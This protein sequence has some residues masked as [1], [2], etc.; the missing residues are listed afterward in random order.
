MKSDKINQILNNKILGSS[1]LVDLLNKYLL[2]I[3]NK[4]SDVIKAVKSASM[5]PGHFEAINSYINEL[6][7]VLK[8]NS[9]SELVKFLKRYSDKAE[10]KIATILNR[11]Y[12]DIKN[13]RSIITL[14]RSGTILKILDLWN[15]KYKPPKVVI[16]EARPKYE[17]RSMA[18]ELAG[19]GIKVEL[20][21]DAMMGLY[22]PKV[23]AAVTGA[24]IILRS[25]NV[26]NKVGSKALAL[27]CRE[28]GKPFYVVADKSK[29]SQRKKFRPNTANPGEVWDKKL[30]NLAVSNIYFEEIERK[31]ITKIFTD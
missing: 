19:A 13:A 1:E 31:L 7:T 6:N 30:K 9:N 17:G 5:M 12:P 2:T 11:I 18:A 14:S 24:D 20:I 23:D 27:F 4:R 10:D 26:I 16:C 22:V 29:C 15:K 25:G 21:T 28:Y 8:R 3:A